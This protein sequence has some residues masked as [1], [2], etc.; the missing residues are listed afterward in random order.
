MQSLALPLGHVT[1]FFYF[2]RVKLFALA[3]D[4]YSRGNKG[5]KDKKKLDNYFL[6]ILFKLTYKSYDKSNR[7]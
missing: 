1:Y 5:G 2:I 7:I 3:I 6:D 4:L